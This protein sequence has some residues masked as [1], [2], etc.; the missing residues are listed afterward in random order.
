MR[1]I[2]PAS[3]HRIDTSPP[4]NQVLQIDLLSLL[5]QIGSFGYT[6]TIGSNGT[7]YNT[8]TQRIGNFDYS[9]TTGSNGYFAATTRQQIGNFGYING[10]SSGGSIS[11]TQQ[12]IGN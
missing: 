3:S 2:I 5:H 12:R 8:T 7:S 9:T 1:S 11:G 4:H 6:N 10:N